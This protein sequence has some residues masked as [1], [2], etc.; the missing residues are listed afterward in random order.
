MQTHQNDAGYQI[1][2]SR[3]K[4]NSKL[5]NKSINNSIL[6]K[7]HDDHDHDK[8]ESTDKI[9]LL[10]QILEDLI[11][12]SSDKKQIMGTLDTIYNDIV[13]TYTDGSERDDNNYRQRQ[14]KDINL[15]T[16][17]KPTH[18]T[19][20]KSSEN[21]ANTL[22]LQEIKKDNETFKLRLN[23]YEIK[24]DN[25]ASE[26]QDLKKQLIEQNNSMIAI[27]REMIDLRSFVINMKQQPSSSTQPSLEREKEKVEKERL[28][29]ITTN[30]KQTSLNMPVKKITSGKNVSTKVP[31]LNKEKDRKLNIIEEKSSSI[32]QQSSPISADLVTTEEKVCG[33]NY[34]GNI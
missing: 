9:H 31:I 13:H 30:F 28:T 33:D 19:D 26:N 8:N 34:T 6:V 7:N 11:S 24:N 10:K 14:E 1:R 2:L 18:S 4:S 15:K 3:E 29:E 16:T 21:T 20:Q 23:S 22:L 25:V 5:K 17:K 32:Q 12:T 27:Q